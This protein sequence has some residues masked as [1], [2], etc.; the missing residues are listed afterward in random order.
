MKNRA[1]AI[2]DYYASVGL[3]QTLTSSPLCLLLMAGLFCSVSNKT[4]F[5]LYSTVMGHMDSQSKIILSV[6]NL[7]FTKLA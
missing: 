6:L 2:T 1:A 4:Y 3:N 7:T 5:V